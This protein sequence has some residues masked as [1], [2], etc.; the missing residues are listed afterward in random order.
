MLGY[1]ADQKCQNTVES[2]DKLTSDTLVFFFC[3]AS[4][5]GFH[6]SHGLHGLT[7]LLIWLVTRRRFYLT[8]CHELLT[9]FYMANT[10]HF[11]KKNPSV[12]KG[13]ISNPLTCTDG[14]RAGRKDQTLT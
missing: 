8:T 6:T 12:E 5:W 9:V 2:H 4:N 11:E 3:S 7:S 1:P 13:L 10:C 14:Y